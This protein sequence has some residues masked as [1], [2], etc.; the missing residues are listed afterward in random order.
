MIPAGQIN[1][2]IC[3]S[4]TDIAYSSLIITLLVALVVSIFLISSH[5]NIETNQKCRFRNGTSGTCV[6][7]SKCFVREKFTSLYIG[8]DCS[9]SSDLTCCLQ[10]NILPDGTK[11]FEFHENFKYFRNKKCGVVPHANY[12]ADR[13]THDS[14]FPWVVSLGHINHHSHLKFTCGGSLISERFILTSAQCVM[15]LESEFKL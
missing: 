13:H 11:D 7:N 4:Y 6:K 2:M 9:G 8:D 3:K 15:P 5:P 12:N 14:E 1:K 10:E